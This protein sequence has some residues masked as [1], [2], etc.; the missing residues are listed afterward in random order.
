MNLIWNFPIQDI[1]QTLLYSF[2]FADLCKRC[3]KKKS[4]YSNFFP[5]SLS[6][7]TTWHSLKLF[8]SFSDY[9]ILF[10]YAVIVILLFVCSYWKV[11]R[12][13][14]VSCGGWIRFPALES[15]FFA[16][17]IGSKM[18]EFAEYRIEKWLAKWYKI[19]TVILWKPYVILSINRKGNLSSLMVAGFGNYGRKNLRLDQV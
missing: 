17:N 4:K 8:F 14:Y 16:F 18:V 19:V 9:N 10:N 5:S 7:P 3:Y 12:L 6:L 1:F 15:S 13:F 11:V 2:I